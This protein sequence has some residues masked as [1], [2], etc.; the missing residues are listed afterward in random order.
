MSSHYLKYGTIIT[1]LGIGEQPHLKALK[2]NQSGIEPTLGRGYNGENWPLS[3]INFLQNNRFHHLL[4]LACDDLNTKVAPSVLCS[5]RTL[6]I[7]STT[8]G[9]LQALAD[10]P[11]HATRSILKEKLGIQNSPIIISNACITGVL[12]INLASDYLKSGQYDDIIVFGIDVISDFIVFGFQ[13]LFALSDEPSQPFDAT[14][15]GITLGEACGVVILSNSRTDEFCVCYCGG[16]TSND[17]NHISGP[18]RTGEGLVRAV[19]K[20]IERSAIQSNSIDFISA[21]GTGTIF[22][23]EMECIAFNRLGLNDVPLNSFK[24]YFGHTLGAAGIIEVIASMLS[25][26][27]KLLFKSLGF[28]NQDSQFTLN[29]LKENQAAPVQTILKTAS[30]FG[31]GNAALILKSLS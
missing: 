2:A 11:F 24:G 12:A 3:Q 29:I 16:A 19:S 10:D 14:R 7:V 6:V 8:K 23:D 26:E 22:N 13:S 30:G 5:S 9:D 17:A 28:N 25:M 31:G 1:P 18:S 21:H 27:N 15:K 4:A 20:A